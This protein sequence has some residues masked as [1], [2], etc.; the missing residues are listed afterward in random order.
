MAVYEQPQHGA[1]APGALRNLIKRFAQPSVAE[2]APHS[3][4]RR[5]PRRPDHHLGEAAQSRDTPS[6]G[7]AAQGGLTVVNLLAATL[8]LALLAGI[9]LWGYR[10]VMRDVSGIPVVR[11]AD[12]P[13]RVQPDDPGG[14]PARNQGLAVNTV[15]ARGA[16]AGPAET[17]ILA[18]PPLDLS[19]NDRQ[20]APAQGAGTAQKGAP[21]ATAVTETAA[22]ADSRVSAPGTD[23]DTT[24]NK[25][26][27]PET[28]AVAT[29]AAG[30]APAAA[31]A[32]AKA[33]LAR[34]LRPV[35]RPG[36]LRTATDIPMA[37][38]DDVK[39]DGG[40]DPDS[41][42]PGT[43]LA[44]LG[45]FD[46]PEVA[47]SEWQRMSERFD[48]YL[49]DKQRVI[50]RAESGGRVF[51]RLRALGFSDLADARRFCSALR[52]EGAECIPVL[53]K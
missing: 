26:T 40:V 46:S 16:A 15:A 32:D 29:G 11:A 10:M 51:Y 7:E 45:A 33:G 50:Q 12:G 28:D 43:R 1:A 4:S 2:V 47:R 39:A 37:Q 49:G 21:D 34:S 27:V 22:G 44:Q 8:S 30:P 5:A 42:P 38:P 14:R 52:Y 35:I 41:I 36:A 13:A 23:E 6:P 3:A 24:G 48:A 9:G 19:L 31:D 17:L 18:P 25:K 53:A 20:G